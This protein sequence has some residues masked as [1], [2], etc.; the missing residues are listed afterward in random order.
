MA[1]VPIQMAASALMAPYDDSDTMMPSPLSCSTRYG[2]SAAMLT[3]AT[4][5]PSAGLP[6]ACVKY[7]DCESTCHAVARRQIAGSSQY[8]MMYATAP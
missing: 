4:R 6:Y 5:V 2:M 3:S 7:S 1:V 8:D